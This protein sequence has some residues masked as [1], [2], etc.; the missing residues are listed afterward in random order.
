[1]VDISNQFMPKMKKLSMS[2]FKS[3]SSKSVKPR[4]V[5]FFWGAFGI[6]KIKEISNKVTKL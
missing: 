6:L 4:H 2:K 1:M 5:H 3:G